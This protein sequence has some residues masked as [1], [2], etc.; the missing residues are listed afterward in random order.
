MR[1]EGSGAR[2]S[3]SE[4]IQFSNFQVVCFC[5]SEERGEVC[6]ARRRDVENLLRRVKERK[7]ERN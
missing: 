6:E 4:K 2:K 3:S 1:S 7:R 5:V